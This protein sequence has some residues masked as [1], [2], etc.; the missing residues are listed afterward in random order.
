MLGNHCI[1]CYC[2]PIKN[3]LYNLNEM[4]FMS[5]IQNVLNPLTWRC[6][7]F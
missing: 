3:I 4:D 7:N 6:L 1:L 5:I 2:L